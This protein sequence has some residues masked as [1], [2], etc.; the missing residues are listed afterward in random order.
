MKENQNNSGIKK[1]EKM[2]QVGDK[3][4]IRIDYKGVTNGGQKINAYDDKGRYGEDV[5]FYNNLTKEQQDEVQKQYEYIRKK[6]PKTIVEKDISK[7][8]KEQN[9]NVHK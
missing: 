8:F 7:L 1:T 3:K 5:E 9:L 4:H 6:Y 2:M